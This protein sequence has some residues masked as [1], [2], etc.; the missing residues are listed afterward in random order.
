M[1]LFSALAA[2]ALRAGG[3]EVIEVSVEEFVSAEARRGAGSGTYAVRLP[4]PFPLG[5]EG[6]GVVIATGPGAPVSPGTRVCWAAV[7]GSC[8]TSVT[9][10]ASMLAPLA[11]G[12]S[13][14]DGACLAVAA[15]TAGGLARVWP[16]KGRQAAVGS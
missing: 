2:K 1:N 15:L 11:E 7:L 5:G 16:L 12:L 6:S 3:P 13:F 4:F 14:E 9:G 8:A 10:P